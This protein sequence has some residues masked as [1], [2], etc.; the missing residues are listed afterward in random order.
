MGRGVVRRETK[1]RI[2]IRDRRKREIRAREGSSKQGRARD[3]CRVYPEACSISSDSGGR[4]DAVSV[5]S[6]GE[7]ESGAICVMGMS[8]P[9]LRSSLRVFV[10]SSTYLPLNYRGKKLFFFFA[11]N[12]LL[13]ITSARNL[14]PS[15]SV[16]RKNK[17]MKWGRKIAETGSVCVALETMPRTE[18]W[19][20]SIAVC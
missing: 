7:E 13:Y 14:Y 12:F 16:R 5:H 3:S 1:G 15:F 11:S 10:F 18:P 20:S 17:K 4:R 2:N 19:S 9:Q 8:C 6:G